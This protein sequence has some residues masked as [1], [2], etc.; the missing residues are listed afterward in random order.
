M[1]WRPRPARSL[2]SSGETRAYLSGGYPRLEYALRMT[3]VVTPGPGP[4]DV[5]IP[6]E[7][8]SR[9]WTCREARNQCLST[10]RHARTVSLV[11][12]NTFLAQALPTARRKQHNMR[13]LLLVLN[14][15]SSERGQTMAEYGILIAVI[16]LIVVVAA[17]TLGS[18]MSTL[19]HN[20]ASHL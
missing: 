11:T 9:L 16:A 5:G 6:G 2:E 15:L 12:E 14:R 17:V 19:F 7:R 20:T 4:R 1:Q 10:D 8:Q 3:R 18:S 13:L